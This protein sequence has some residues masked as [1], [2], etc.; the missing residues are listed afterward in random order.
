MLMPSRNRVKQYVEH[1]YYH[2]YNRG[3]SKQEIFLDKED[4]A[5]F[6]NLLKRHLDTAPHKD[7]KGRE[8][9]WLHNDL[10]L[11]AY[12]LMPNHFHFLIYQREPRAIVSL[13]KI[14][15]MSYSSYFNKKYGRIGPL[16]QGTYKGVLIQADAYLQHISRYIHLNPKLYLKWDYSSLPYY[17]GRQAANWL[18]P[19]PI[20]ELFD[21]SPRQYQKFLADYV[22]HKKALD[23]IKRSLADQ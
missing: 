22:G 23:E 14:V 3:I 1:G 20:M 19:R 15:T 7:L 6:L 21:N 2:I 10:N 13:M 12:C 16:F 8:L 4:Y 9:M 17:L 5:V 11:L 18:N